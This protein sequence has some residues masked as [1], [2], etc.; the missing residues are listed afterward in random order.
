MKAKQK[1]NTFENKISKILGQWMF[2]DIHVLSRHLTSGA[3]KQVYCGDIIPIKQLDEYKEWKNKFP[4]LIETKHGYPQHVPTV[5]S[6]TKV[7][8]WY[9]KSYQ[10]SLLNKQPIIFLI[11]QFK[12]KKTILIT[13]Y[14]I[15]VNKFLFNSVFPIQINGDLHYTYVYIFGEL[16]KYNFHDLFNLEEILN[17]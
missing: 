1:G 8:E 16:L 11:C 2:N 14:L 7:G 10:E 6:F 5:W 9:I 4:F 13:N 17:S 15:D 12:N 3:Q